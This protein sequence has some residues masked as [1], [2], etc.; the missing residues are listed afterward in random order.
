[1]RFPEPLVRAR[2]IRRYKRFLADVR[3]A[4]GAEAVAHC[5]DPG[6]MIGLAEPGSEVWLSPA[7]GAARKLAWTW[8]LVRVGA[9]LVGVNSALPNR[10]AEEAIRARRIPELAGWDGLRR[11]VAYGRRSR[12]D[13]L[14]E[15]GAGARCYVEVKNVHLKREAGA[16]FPDTVT[17]R[18]RRHLDELA[19]M[20]DAGHRAVM[21]YL[22]QREDCADFRIAAD[23]DPAYDAALRRAR[24]HGVEALCYACRVSTAE[25]VL[26]RPLP[27]VG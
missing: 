2:L 19:D 7:R 15:T 23:I 11:E 12:I 8:Q 21:L 14:L 18:G 27:I 24:A 3:F 22:V 5:A 9:G 25:I 26:A 13:L 1:M 4:D 16:E 6:K 20:A 17:E 10:I